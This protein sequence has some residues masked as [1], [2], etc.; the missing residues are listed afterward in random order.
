MSI[1]YS[2]SLTIRGLVIYSAENEIV[3]LG[4]ELDTLSLTRPICARYRCLLL[5][6]HQWC[7]FLLPF[8]NLIAQYMAF[9][10]L[11]LYMLS[12]ILTCLGSLCLNQKCKLWKTGN[13]LSLAIVIWSMILFI[14]PSKQQYFAPKASQSRGREGFTSCLGS[15]WEKLKSCIQQIFSVGPRKDFLFLPFIWFEK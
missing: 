3:S 2:Q 14:T 11:L 6:Y 4:L 12:S 9:F 8:N 13:R 7:L 5:V 10:M 15:D 1:C